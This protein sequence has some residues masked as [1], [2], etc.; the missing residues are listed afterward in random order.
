VSQFR[1]I[2]VP[3]DGSE[4]AERALE[5]A[6]MIARAVSA[7]VVLFRVAEP[8]SRTRELARM[9]DLYHDF[10]TAAHREADAYLRS[11][12]EGLSYAR[13]SIQSRSAADGVARQILDFV[14]E[15]DVDLIVM[16]SHGRSG[17]SRWVH[18]SVA[19]KVL[20]G[21]SCAILLIRDGAES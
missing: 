7:E 9:P 10:I 18:G 3:L 12:H 19:E 11:L 6:L 20:S 13:L 16:S 21:A 15:S 17:V 1:R 2:L 4:L 14:A 5:P 8:I